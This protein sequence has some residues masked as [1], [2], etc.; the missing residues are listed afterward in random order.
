MTARTGAD[1]G[2]VESRE[3]TRKR[4]GK[5][6][7]RIVARRC[8]GWLVQVGGFDAGVQIGTYGL[9]RVRMIVLVTMTVVVGRQRVEQL[10]NVVR[11]TALA[12]GGNEID[13]LIEPVA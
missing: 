10:Q 12:G 3:L 1:Q 6:V 9:V 13:D 8:R 4:H 2:R 5:H 7:T 11:T